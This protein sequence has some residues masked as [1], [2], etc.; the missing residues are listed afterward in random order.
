MP[1]DGDDGWNLRDYFFE[2]IH[3]D[4]FKTCDDDCC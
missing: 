4:C 1:N 2:S 3:V